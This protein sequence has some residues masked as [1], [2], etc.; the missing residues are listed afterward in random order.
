MIET[1]FNLIHGEYDRTEVTYVHLQ[2]VR[3]IKKDILPQ[4]E[5]QLVLP[6]QSVYGLKDMSKRPRNTREKNATSDIEQKAIL[7]LRLDNRVGT[8]TRIKFRSSMRDITL[9]SINVY[10]GLKRKCTV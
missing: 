5:Q 3:R 2:Q 4:V 8:A 7:G 9:S 1:R 10:E 6:V